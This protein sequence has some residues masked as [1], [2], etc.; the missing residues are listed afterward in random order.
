VPPSQREYALWFAV[1]KGSAA[2]TIP[3]CMAEPCIAKQTRLCSSPLDFSS[4]ILLRFYSHVVT[5]DWRLA[6]EMQSRARGYQEPGT[7]FLLIA[8]RE[9]EGSRV[10]RI[11]LGP[12]LRQCAIL[13][14]SFQGGI[15]IALPERKGTCVGGSSRSA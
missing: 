4:A 3:E 12:P 5:K 13:S 14:I 7:R 8:W 1:P 11:A 9:I 10:G 6:V 15:I 2:G